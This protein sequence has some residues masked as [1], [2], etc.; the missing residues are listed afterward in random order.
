MS[1]VIPIRVRR[2]YGIFLLTKHCQARMKQR[3]IGFKEMKDTIRRGIIVHER[4]GV[5]K[6]I[7]GNINVIFEQESM[8]IYTVFRTN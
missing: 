7:C 6:V 3:G 8:R 4:K 1:S 5:N 2:G